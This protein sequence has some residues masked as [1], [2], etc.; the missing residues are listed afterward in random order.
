MIKEEKDIFKP[1]SDDHVAEIEKRRLSKFPKYRNIKIKGTG[2][3]ARVEGEAYNAEMDMW[4]NFEGILYI[5]MIRFAFTKG[6]EDLGRKIWALQDGLRG[7]KPEDCDWDWSAIRDSSPEAKA[8]IFELVSKYV[9]VNAFEKHLRASKGSGEE[10]LGSATEAKLDRVGFSTLVDKVKEEVFKP[11]SPEEEEEREKANPHPNVVC[12]VCGVRMSPYNEGCWAYFIDSKG[13][14]YSRMRYGDEGGDASVPCHDCNVVGG[15]VHHDGCDMERCP[16]CGGQAISCGCEFTQVTNSKP[17][18]RE[19]CSKP[20][21]KFTWSLTEGVSQAKKL[22]VDTRKLSPRVFAKLVAYDPTEQKKYIEW[23]ARVFF[24][25][26]MHHEDL[27]KFEAIKKFDEL[28]NKNVIT[29]KDINQYANI[30]AVYDEVKKHEDVKTKGEEEREIKGNAEAVFQN[31][32]VVIIFPKDKEASCVY[33]KGTKWCT[34]ADSSYNYFNRY[35]FDQY[36]NLYYILPK[37]EYMQKYGKIA[38]A[39]ERGGKKTYFDATD[40]SHDDAWFRPIAKDLGIPVSKKKTTESVTFGG[41]LG[42]TADVLSAKT[43][44][45]RWDV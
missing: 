39:V 21:V 35:F 2:S 22:Y 1:Q 3:S 37:G 16:K 5:M 10:R 27:P 15:A 7:V 13:K 26:R 45:G 29:Q 19:S 28:C 24:K 44:K 11:V 6:S 41:L 4:T 32:K 42:C 18:A 9:D 36:T 30:E 34:S 12:E 43:G 8:S 20:T 17:T 38:V 14:C 40:A 31:N 25:E 23:I 33:G